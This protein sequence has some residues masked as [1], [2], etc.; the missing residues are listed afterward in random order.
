MGKRMNLFV[1][2][3]A[4]YWV[5]WFWSNEKALVAM[6]VLPIPVAVITAYNYL[7]LFGVVGKH[8]EG[9]AN[10]ITHWLFLVVGPSLIWF[11]WHLMCHARWRCNCMEQE[12][13]TA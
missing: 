9:T 13:K 1:S 4:A 12:R 6:Q 11:G 2:G 8:S 5:I 10:T 3:L 7:T